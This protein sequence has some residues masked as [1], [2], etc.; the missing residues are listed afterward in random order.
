MKGILERLAAGPVIGDGGFVFELEKRG[1][2]KGG[3]WTPEAVVEHPE[4]VKQL[5]REF[6]RAGSDVMQAFTYYASEDKLVNRGNQVGVKIGV[7]AIKQEVDL[8]FQK[9]A[10][11]PIDHNKNECAVRKQ[12]VIKTLNSHIR[13]CLQLQ[14]AFEVPSAA[15]THAQGPS[16]RISSR[17]SA[18]ALVI[19]T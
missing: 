6:L 12:H 4:A 10:S 18:V 17:A 2:V 11:L 13:E 8:L 14:F 7:D 5:H 19:T 9:A 1:Y 3:P 16:L 15:T